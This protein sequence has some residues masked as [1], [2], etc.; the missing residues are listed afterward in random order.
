MSSLINMM[1]GGT[2][3][4]RPV[5]HHHITLG[6]TDR[7]S[8]PLST[9]TLSGAPFQ[10]IP[11]INTANDQPRRSDNVL[12][13]AFS[14]R[15]NRSQPDAVPLF[16]PRSPFRPIPIRAPD[17]VVDQYRTNDTS[18]LLNPVD[19]VPLPNTGV[20]QPQSGALAFQTPPSNNVISNQPHRSHG[21]RNPLDGP[22]QP[23]PR[24]VV[25]LRSPPQLSQISPPDIINI[26]LPRTT[27]QP[28]LLS[29][30]IDIVPRPRVVED[31]SLPQPHTM[32]RHKT[33]AGT[34]L[35]NP[36]AEAFVPSW[37]VSP[38]LF[39]STNPYRDSA[40][41]TPVTTPGLT[42]DHSPMAFDAPCRSLDY[43]HKLTTKCVQH[44]KADLL[45][46]PP[47]LVPSKYRR[48]P[49]PGLFLYSPP[50]P[51]LARHTAYS[52]HHPAGIA[53]M[54]LPPVE[55][56]Y[57]P[58]LGHHRYH[59]Q[60][61]IARLGLKDVEYLNGCA[62]SWELSGAKVDDVTEKYLEKTTRLSVPLA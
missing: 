15:R 40:D 28:N 62:W 59:S 21:L 6:D 24:R 1:N 11:P 61:M 16:Q 2:S 32:P 37:L 50:P 48:R 12:S 51:G 56:S 49:S 13:R 27:D 14:S 5:S 8:Q 18:N 55:I 22:V 26:N 36:N 23:M 35:L 33:T 45:R 29:S 58:S 10:A 31:R 39:S 42:P 25:E 7:Q 47:V 38:P 57:N 52:P 60:K 54:S 44:V 46:P 30:P 9:H 19:F 41:S 3:A 4:D 53:V 43:T 17:V 34:T 20:S